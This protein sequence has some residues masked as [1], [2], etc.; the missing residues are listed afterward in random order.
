MQAIKGVLLSLF[1]GPVNLLEHHILHIRIHAYADA[2]VAA[3]VA[4]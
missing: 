3:R 4:A 2:H 1:F